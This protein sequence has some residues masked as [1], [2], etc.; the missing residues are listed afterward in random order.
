MHSASQWSPLRLSDLAVQVI[1]TSLRAIPSKN[2]VSVSVSPSDVR[3]APDEAHSLALVINELA[4]NAIKYA[5]GERDAVRITFEVAPD[6]DE[7]RCTF[8]DD[9]PGYPEEILHRTND[10]GPPGRQTAGLDLIRNILRD[11]LHGELFLR[12]D[13]GALAIVRLKAETETGKGPAE[14]GGF[15]RT[16][17]ETDL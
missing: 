14:D 3:V 13:D 9:G 12:N 5:L 7:V 11:S 16:Q 4:T 6:G 15:S 17:K 2:R 10:Q 8:R 1:N